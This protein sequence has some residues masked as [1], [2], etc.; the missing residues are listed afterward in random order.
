[1]IV[2]GQRLDKETTVQAM[3]SSP[4][5]DELSI[6]GAEV[7]EL[8]PGS[9]AITYRFRGRRGEA[10]PYEAEMSSVYE[11]RDGDEWQLVLHQQTPLS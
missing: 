8:G 2:P 5:W 11:R 3:N 4:G 6:E 7:L 10:E 9:A 1:M